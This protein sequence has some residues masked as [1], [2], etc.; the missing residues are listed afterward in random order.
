[1]P[2]MIPAR[3]G[4]NTKSKAEIKVFLGFSAMPETENWTIMHSVGIAK[5]PTQSQGEADFVV[6][7]PEKG[8]FTLEVKGGTIYR[9]RGIWYSENYYGISN[10]IKDPVAEANE[11][12]QAFKGFVSKSPRNPAGDKLEGTVFGFGVMFPDCSFHDKISLIELADEQLADADD[13]VSPAALKAYL[14]RLAEF[15]RVAFRDNNKVKRPSA[16]QSRLITDILRPDFDA[17][18]SLQSTIRNVENKVL[19]LT[20]NQLSVLDGLTDNDR[21]LVK[22]GAGTGKTTLALNMA[23]RM[24]REG[25][26]IGLFCFNKQLAYDL[27]NKTAGR[28]GIL[29]DSFTEYMKKVSRQG[30][31][32]VPEEDSKA[33]ADYFL[34]DLPEHFMEAYDALGLPQFDFL[35]LDEGQDLMRPQYLD[36]MD[37]ILKGGLRDGSW[38]FFMDAERQDLYGA[39][40]GADTVKAELRSRNVSYTNY[41]LTDNCRN[42]RSIMEKIDEIFGTKSRQRS[43]AERGEAVRISA[44][45]DDAD[46]LRQLEE[47]LGN[48]KKDGVSA[49]QIVIL[50]TLRFENSVV[51]DLSGLPITSDYQNRKGKILFSTVHTFKGLDA[52]VVILTDINHFFYPN[53][54]MML[55]VGMSRA[56]SLLYVL[57]RE[58][59]YRDIQEFSREK[60]V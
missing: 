44:Y 2:K 48:L 50:S 28:E 29:C 3:M 55:Y 21:C 18:I 9:D 24:C 52:P 23:E 58:K 19:E 22:G 16:H 37:W 14:L 53:N 56:K 38:Y 4:E 42:S 54:K 20:E 46:Q 43:D 33:E 17:R 11:A 1:M 59:T 31:F 7:I 12:S 34:N 30:G 49:D 39:A 10:P 60:T 26:K 8:T 51:K 57:C 5:H 47:I 15:W 36:A 41:S 13:C 40:G 35:I 27:R 32:E 45:R 25:L 6:I